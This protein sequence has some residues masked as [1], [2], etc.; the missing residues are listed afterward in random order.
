VSSA[1]LAASEDERRIELHR[2]IEG[3]ADVLIEGADPLSFFRG[4]PVLQELPRPR[5][6]AA[7][8]PQQAAPVILEPVIVAGRTQP[9]PQMPGS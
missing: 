6:Q 9:M 8:L 5:A 1:V 7:Q 4:S 2:P 3:L